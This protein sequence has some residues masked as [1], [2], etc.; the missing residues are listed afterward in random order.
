MFGFGTRD[1]KLFLL[2]ALGLLLGLM[3]FIPIDDWWFLWEY[4]E[5]TPMWIVIGQAWPFALVAFVITI[6]IILFREFVS[7]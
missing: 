4:I 1:I 2:V 6:F 3:F 7:R 5:T